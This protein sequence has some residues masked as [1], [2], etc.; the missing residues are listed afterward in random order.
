MPL[1]VVEVPCKRAI[2][3]MAINDPIVAVDEQPFG[4]CS[5]IV[6]GLNEATVPAGLLW[7]EPSRILRE[8]PGPEDIDLPTPRRARIDAHA[9]EG[10]AVLT[11]SAWW[12]ATASSV[13]GRGRSPI[14]PI[15]SDPLAGHDP[16]A[17]KGLSDMPVELQSPT[18]SG[19]TLVDITVRD[20]IQRIAE[21]A[22]RQGGGL[23]PCQF[24]PRVVISKA[25]VVRIDNT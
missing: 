23:N 21:I 8:H 10:F 20:R 13:S 6:I 5:G 7:I 16:I 12:R 24:C 2:R 18:A 14:H 22:I 9:G 3:L 1:Q 4:Q 17:A 19:S 15:Q 11:G 25:E